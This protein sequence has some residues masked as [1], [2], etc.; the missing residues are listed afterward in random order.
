MSLERPN[1][2][3]RNNAY[4]ADMNV[5]GSLLQPALQLMR[6]YPA[7]E[8]EHMNWS[9]SIRPGIM[10]VQGQVTMRAKNPDTG[11]VRKVNFR[12]NAEFWGTREGTVMATLNLREDD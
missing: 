8:V 6:R 5:K 10:T 11:E 12:L 4:L 7:V 9:D 3:K 2:A 1:R